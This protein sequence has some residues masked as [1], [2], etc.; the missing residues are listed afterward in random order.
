MKYFLGLLDRFI[1][2]FFL[3]IIFMG[4]FVWMY[5]YDW[6]RWKYRRWRKGKK[7]N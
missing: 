5:D 2:G 4:L 7:K 3:S 1:S 6:W